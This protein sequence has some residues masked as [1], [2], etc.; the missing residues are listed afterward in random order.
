MRFWRS[1]AVALDVRPGEGQAT[2]L[3]FV[4]SFVLGLARPLISTAANAIYLSQL[5]PSSLPYMYIGIAIIVT[6]EGLAVSTLQRRL[7][8]A[9]FLVTVIVINIAALCVAWFLIAVVQASWVALGLAIWNSV[10]GVLTGLV[11]WGLAGRIFDVR[12]AKRLFGLVGS[13]E[14]VAGVIAGASVSWLVTIIGTPNLLLAAA[15]GLAVFLALLLA[16]LR[17][18]ASRLGG[19]QAGSRESERPRGNR[20]IAQLLRSRYIVLLIAVAVA[21]TFAYNFLDASFLATTRA[22]FAS[23]SELAGF[24]GIFYGTLSAANLVSRSISGRILNRLGVNFGLLVVPIGLTV[25]ITGLVVLGILGQLGFLIFWIVVSTRLLY[26]VASRSFSDP[27]RSLLYQ[28]LPRQER[29]ATQTVVETVVQPFAGGLA[30]GVLLLFSALAALD[31]VRV[32]YALLV[33]LVGWIVVSWL[34]S[35]GYVPMLYR[36]AGDADVGKSPA[37]LEQPVGP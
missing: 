30:G 26:A 17:T 8:F 21:G 18:Q 15:S 7:A 36:R 31:A 13:G 34:A 23:Q 35:R 14:A 24:F 16:A 22:H 20:G 29:L 10:V 33:V 5:D 28:L 1:F 9:T 6:V 25:A 32:G 37:E 11:F 12:Q 27:S 19:P 2:V 3:L 4:L